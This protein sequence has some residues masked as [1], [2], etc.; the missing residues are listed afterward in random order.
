ML[1]Q[2]IRMGVAFAIFAARYPQ[3]SRHVSSHQITGLLR[4]CIY[5]LVSFSKIPPEDQ[6]SVAMPKKLT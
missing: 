5:I 2:L 4:A 1:S 6:I 3:K